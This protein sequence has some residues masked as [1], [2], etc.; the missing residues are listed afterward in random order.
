MSDNE[1]SLCIEDYRVF[2]RIATA[3]ELIRDDLLTRNKLLAESNEFA[4]KHAEANDVIIE[5]AKRMEAREQ[6]DRGLRDARVTDA[7]GA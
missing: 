1:I 3:L 5:A 7:D 4:R 6:M 2:E